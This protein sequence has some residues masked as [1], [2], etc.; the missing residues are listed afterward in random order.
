MNAVKVCNNEKGEKGN[1]VAFLCQGLCVC[2]H[3]AK[4]REGETEGETER[5]KERWGRGRVGGA[6]EERGWGGVW[7]E[8]ISRGWGGGSNARTRKGGALN[9]CTVCILSQVARKLV[10]LARSSLVSFRGLFSIKLIYRSLITGSYRFEMPHSRG[11]FLQ[12][13]CSVGM[14]DLRRNIRQ[15]ENHDKILIVVI[16]PSEQR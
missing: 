9:W 11:E 13:R 2:A 1:E 8:G 7:K 3:I 16:E 14:G 4:E 6:A 5:R 10:M 12:V 15:T